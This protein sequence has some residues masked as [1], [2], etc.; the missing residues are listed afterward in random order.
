MLLQQMLQYFCYAFSLDCLVA[1][2]HFTMESPDQQSDECFVELC[3]EESLKVA[4]SRSSRYIGRHCVL[5]MM[6][7]LSLKLSQESLFCCKDFLCVRFIIFTRI[8]CPPLVSHINTQSR[9]SR[10][11]LCAITASPDF[12][13]SATIR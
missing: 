2:I 5:G 7:C 8:S 1:E 12:Y 6:L 3:N 4:L 11:W 10:L 13:K 9:K